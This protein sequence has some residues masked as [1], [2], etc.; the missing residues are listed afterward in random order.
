[1]DA[2]LTNSYLEIIQHLAERN[3]GLESEVE[4]LKAELERLQAG[5]RQ[6]DEEVSSLRAELR[7][8][9]SD[10]YIH[11]MHGTVQGDAYQRGASSN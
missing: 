1:M 2:H 4:Q 3:A 10:V 11:E 8:R 6:R 5:I 7:L 9:K